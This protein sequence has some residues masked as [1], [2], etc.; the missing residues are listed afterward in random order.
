MEL[1]PYGLEAAMQGIWYY[2]Y[3]IEYFEPHSQKA[4]GGK[5]TIK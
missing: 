3:I 4:K 5:R 2:L 1:L